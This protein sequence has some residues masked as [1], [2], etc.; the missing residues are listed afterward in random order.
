MN[1]KDN[2]SI[3]TST[4]HRN[5]PSPNQATSLI[6]EVHSHYRVESVELLERDGIARIRQYGYEHVHE[7]HGKDRGKRGN[8]YCESVAE[9]PVLE[10]NTDVRKQHYSASHSH[11]D[12][13]VFPENVAN[14]AKRGKKSVFGIFLH[15][16]DEEEYAEHYNHARKREQPYLHF[17]FFAE[18]SVH[19]ISPLQM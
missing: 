4:T 5:A 15:S 19:K 17:L 1:T 8:A 9:F 11:D 12:D 18:R 2:R 3:T 14:L 16:V 7:R 13:D 10:S 6:Y